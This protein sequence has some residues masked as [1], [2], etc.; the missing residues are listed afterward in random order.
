MSTSRTTS[1]RRYS[2]PVVCA[3][4]VLAVGAVVGQSL[5]SGMQVTHGQATAVMSGNR[6]NVTAADKSVLQWQ[7]FSI[8]AGNT[9]SF[10]LP[11]SA[12]RVLNQVTG[13]NPSQI[14]GT[15]S[16]NGQV[17]LINPNGIVFGAGSRVDVASLVASSL[18]ISPAD[19]VAGQYRFSAPAGSTA[20][21]LNQ[22]D[23]RTPYGGR[24]VMLGHTVGNSGTLRADG[25]SV[26]MLG[27]DSVELVD[28][29]TPHMAV[30]APVMAGQVS[31]SGA[32][33]AGTVDVYGAAV[34]QQG[35]IVAESMGVNAQGEVVLRASG[36]VS[37]AAGSQTQASGGRIT[38]ASDNGT[39]QVDGTVQTSAVQGNGGSIRMDA[40]QLYVG[41]GAQVLADGGGVGDGGRIVLWGYDLMSQ[42]GLVSARGGA[43]GGNGGFIETST[44][45]VFDLE[46]IPTAAAPSG[47]PGTWLIDP[48]N[49]TVVAAPPLV[50]M[51]NVSLIAIGPPVDH[52]LVNGNSAVVSVDLIQASLN[53]G[54]S[55]MLDTNAGGGSQPGHIY[56][57]AP[58]LNVSPVAPASLNL[59]A[60]GDIHI[61]AS[62]TGD[63][64][65]AMQLSTQ[66]TLYL[67]TSASL[68]AADI[69]IPFGT[70]QLVGKGATAATN[71]ASVAM[72]QTLWPAGGTPSAPGPGTGTAGGTGSTDANGLQSKA[73]Y[74]GA[75]GSILDYMP[76]T[77]MPG[78]KVVASNP[79][80]DLLSQP[81]AAAQLPGYR[82]MVS[83]QTNTYFRVIPVSEMTSG[84]IDQVLHARQEYKRTLLADATQALLANPA[85]PDLPGCA[86]AAESTS[87]KC[88]LDPLKDNA[89]PQ[90]AQRVS[91]RDKR[92]VVPAVPKIARKVALVMGINRYDDTRIPQLV[93]A[94][95]DA[96][97]V[98]EHLQEEL[99][100][101]VV[102]L[103]NP[104]KAQVFASLNALAADLGESDSL[105]VYYA[106]HG[107]MVEATG[108]GYWIPSDGT[109]DS[110]KGWVSNSDIN[111]LLARSK[112]RQIGVIADSCY[113]GR[114]T[115]E[116][117]M[118]DSPVA[119]SIDDLLLKR[120]VTMMSSGGDEPVADTG[121][122]G[123]SVFAWNLMQKMR[124]V[125]GWSSGSDVFASIRTAVESELPQTP[126]YGA[127]VVAGHQQGADFIFERRSSAPARAR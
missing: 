108:M 120:A 87:G 36:N 110:P 23:I 82:Y 58:L 111:K 102:M 74:T 80:M 31:N 77:G 65:F 121:K 95:P 91:S 56:W 47:R 50:V 81:G 39:A 72:T 116:S 8:G 68:S 97:A 98:D 124:E 84:D 127:S 57:N 51:S 78:T 71:S 43:L 89:K 119:R 1:E 42:R 27:V 14:L 18:Y 29:G 44:H 4:L 99:G 53:A 100:Y 20:Q 28:T 11:T 60:A 32:V 115:A 35:S 114:F 26:T 107:E 69:Y 126:Q 19:F 94:L 66:N 105:L 5:P 122:D 63:A 54:T 83:D 88:L 73:R 41:N 76:V 101:D 86:S 17:W 52:Y 46:R 90:L 2:R 61:N 93:G 113:S 59:F 30:R 104:T 24:I 25:G 15:L 79:D 7:Q 92:S 125:A 45:G 12:S 10:Q 123:H 117:K 16:S 64:N 48:Y 40:R 6:L 75:S 13:G 49:L 55:V 103:N 38:V 9:V 109:A 112:S 21:V 106:G 96:Q 118:D 34:N 3:V 67:D 62:I 33:A 37:L 85:L 22:G 70:V